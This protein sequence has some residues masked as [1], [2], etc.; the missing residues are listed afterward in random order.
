[1]VGQ[2][3]KGNLT[4]NLMAYL[5]YS[6]FTVLGKQVVAECTLSERKQCI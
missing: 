5:K 1:M 2:P 4:L 3:M 6:I